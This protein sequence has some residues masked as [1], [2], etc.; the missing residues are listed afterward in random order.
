MCHLR[1]KASNVKIV[2]QVGHSKPTN[3]TSRSGVL[4]RGEHCIEQLPVQPIWIEE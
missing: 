1:L 2:P 3:R 4:R